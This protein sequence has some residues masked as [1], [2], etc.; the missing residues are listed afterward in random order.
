M[1]MYGLP[2]AGGTEQVTTIM[3]TMMMKMMMMMMTM[4]MMTKIMMMMMM[5]TMMVKVMAMMITKI[6]SVNPMPL[7]ANCNAIFI[8]SSILTFSFAFFTP[9]CNQCVFINKAKILISVWFNSGLLR[10]YRS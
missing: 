8:R 2:G 3:I 10:C 7:R 9:C 5:A 6:K 1:N 4:M